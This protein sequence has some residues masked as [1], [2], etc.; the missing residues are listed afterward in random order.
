MA[1]EES[2][3][4]V[5]VVE[6]QHARGGVR[7]A[8]VE[9]V[10][11]R[12]QATEHGPLVVQVHRVHDRRGDGAH[13][14]VLVPAVLGDVASQ[15]VLGVGHAC[16]GGIGEAVGIERGTVAGD[17]VERAGIGRAVGAVA[18]LVVRIFHAGHEF[19]LQAAQVAVPQYVGLV[20]E[21]FH[22]LPSLVEGLGDRGVG[23]TGIVD[24][25]GATA[26]GRECVPVV[27]RAITRAAHDAG[28]GA[29]AVGDAGG[30]R[31]HVAVQKIGVLG[32][33]GH[34][35]ARRGGASVAI[36]ERA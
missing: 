17:A 26:C 22:F 20:R 5:E 8:V 21:V 19:M 27:R 23:A 29:Q 10:V 30:E 2:V 16:T 34:V 14:P 13:A 3:A 11:V 31:V 7:L 9:L 18:H 4:G 35:P 25:G 1:V 24:A 6:S 28:I 12:T 33:H 15:E 32:D 36:E